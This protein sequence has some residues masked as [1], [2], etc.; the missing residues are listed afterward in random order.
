MYDEFQLKSI[1][2]KI[3]QTARPVIA[4]LRSKKERPKKTENS[5]EDQKLQLAQIEDL[6][7]YAKKAQKG[8]VTLKEYKPISVEAQ[9]KAMA[10][11]EGSAVERIAAVPPIYYYHPDHLGTSTAL[12]DFNGNAYQIEDS[13]NSTENKHQVR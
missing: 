1:T 7:Y 12:T 10:A 13:S 6:N 8:K 5:F 9:E 3:E 11:E 2:K 4:R